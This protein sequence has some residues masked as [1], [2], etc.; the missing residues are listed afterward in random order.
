MEVVS[1]R[2][3]EN[4]P[5]EE[6]VQLPELQVSWPQV[7]L[8]PVLCALASPPNASA[9]RTRAAPRQIAKSLLIELAPLLIADL[10][11]LGHRT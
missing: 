7:A 2:H 6:G 9:P 1:V 10:E 11:P 3:D 8:E 4:M 5:P